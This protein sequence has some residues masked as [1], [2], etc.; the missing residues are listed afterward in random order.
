[1]KLTDPRELERVFLMEL[2]WR[3]DHLHTA[4]ANR[5]N[6][7][8]EVLGLKAVIT[9]RLSELREENTHAKISQQAAND[10]R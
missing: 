3:V 4:L 7:I 5:R 2:D 9:N 1:M 6:G 10:N 8:P